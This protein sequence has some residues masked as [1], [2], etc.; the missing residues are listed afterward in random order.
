[1]LGEAMPQ[2]LGG[3]VAVAHMAHI[4][5]TLFGAVVC[6]ILLATRLLPRD[7]FDM[8]AL[9][10]RWNRRRTYRDMVASGYNPFGYTGPA[11]FKA[12]G[13]PK[14]PDAAT[15]RLMD[16]RSRISQSAA[17]HDLPEAA[18]LYG[19]LIALDSNQVM[20]R[21]V[22]L[23][24]ANFLASQQRYPE[25][26][27]AYEQFLRF[28]P[29]YDQIEQVDLMLGVIYS[30]YLNK[31]LRAKECLLRAIARLHFSR[32]IDLAKAE[33]AHVEATMPPGA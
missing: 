27:A 21:G 12:D 32:E 8:V 5:G 18:D 24:L 7:K 17:A 33:L 30:R 6:S 19:Q 16:M 15:Q 2:L 29:N 31:P 25:A 13:P 10:Q 11:R 20:A 26:A 23:D 14:P 4:S 1:V 22:Q 3:D 28:Y 9:A